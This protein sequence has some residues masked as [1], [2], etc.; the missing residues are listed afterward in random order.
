MHTFTSGGAPSGC[1]PPDVDG[2]PSRCEPPH[3]CERPQGCE[4]PKLP[5]EVRA[6]SQSQWSLRVT[7][8]AAAKADLELLGALL[9]HKFGRDLPAILREAVRCGIEKHGRRRG[10][11]APQRRRRRESRTAGP[12]TGPS[13]TRAARSRSPDVAGA[14]TPAEVE[15]SVHVKPAVV[16][17]PPIDQTHRAIPAEVRRQVFER[18]GGACT[19]IGE[20]GRRCGSRHQ[21]EVDHIRPYARGGPATVGNLRLLCRAHNLFHAEQ[22]FGQEHMAQFRRRF[23]PHV[24]RDAMAQAP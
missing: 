9:S 21:I 18:D 2:S 7:L 15:D 19:W 11:V 20:N 6:V 14:F 17:P 24:D 1:V 16:Q 8:D 5:S 12:D 13:A 4:R 10:A 3:G 23:P 22:L